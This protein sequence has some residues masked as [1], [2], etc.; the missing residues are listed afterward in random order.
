MNEFL[1]RI[2]KLLDQAED[3]LDEGEYD[4]LLTE[5]Q[6]NI[7]GRFDDQGDDLEDDEDDE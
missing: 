5:V 1:A 2:T 3:E 6:E 4:E 7:D